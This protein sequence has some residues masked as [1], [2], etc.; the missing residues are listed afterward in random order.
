MDQGRDLDVGQSVLFLDCRTG[1][2]R[3]ALLRGSAHEDAQRDDPGDVGPECQAGMVSFVQVP[4]ST[5][6][7]LAYRAWLTSPK[8]FS[9]YL[10][11]GDIPSGPW[12]M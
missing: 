1:S 3:E 12:C 4:A 7:D 9:D 8:R 6:A 2:E 11:G 5:S 10:P